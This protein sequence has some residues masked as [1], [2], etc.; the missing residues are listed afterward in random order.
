MERKKERRKSQRK[1]NTYSGKTWRPKMGVILFM[2]PKESRLG[3][4]GLTKLSWGMA[5]RRV[6][7]GHQVAIARRTQTQGAESLQGDQG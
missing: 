5:K 1:Y 6:P 3:K 2:S 4:R 7:I